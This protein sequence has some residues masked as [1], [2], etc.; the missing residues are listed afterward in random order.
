LGR[1]YS[2]CKFV[3]DLIPPSFSLI[4]PP[5]RFLCSSSSVRINIWSLGPCTISAK[6]SW[7]DILLFR[8]F[9]PV[10]FHFK[11]L[12]VNSPILQYAFLCSFSFFIDRT[13]PALV[14]YDFGIRTW[15]SPPR[16]A[17]A[18]CTRFLVSV[19]KYI[20]LEKGFEI[21]LLSDSRLIDEKIRIWTAS[22]SLCRRSPSLVNRY[23]DWFFQS[24]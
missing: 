4:L 24:V 6:Y 8:A 20:V 9:H 13:L 18:L 16:P 15:S 23:S 17:P 14:K 19:F 12:I 5:I 21:R 2:S 10:S 11:L 3:R 1:K 22:V 7:S